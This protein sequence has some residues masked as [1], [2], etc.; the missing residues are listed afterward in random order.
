MD[1]GGG[2]ATLAGLETTVGDVTGGTGGT[3]ASRRRA[4]DSLYWFCL[5]LRPWSNLTTIALMAGICWSRTAGEASSSERHASRQV[6]SSVGTL[7]RSLI[8]I[9]SRA[10]AAQ[11][12][13]RSFPS[14][15]YMSEIFSS[16]QLPMLH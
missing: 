8:D 14:L 13:L 10:K 1:P 11:A 15:T 4:S 12:A 7:S 2:E 3:S 16:V 9:F 6:R 5:V